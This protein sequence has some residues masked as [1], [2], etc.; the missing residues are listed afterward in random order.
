[1]FTYDSNEFTTS[2]S[3]YVPN[4]FDVNVIYNLTKLY[5]VINVNI[6]VKFAIDL[7]MLILI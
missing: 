5:V 7:L 3:S 4:K 1:M 2:D 6:R